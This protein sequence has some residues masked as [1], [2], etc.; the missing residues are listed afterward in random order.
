MILAEHKSFSTASSL[1]ILS[2]EELIKAILVLLHSEE[3]KVYRLKEANKFFKDHSIRHHLA[4][5]IETGKGLLEAREKWGTSNLN[6]ISTKTTIGEILNHVYSGFQA[7]KPLSKSIN[8]VEKLQGFNTLKNY[9]FY[10]DYSDGLK[11]PKVEIT[12]S[13][14]EDVVSINQRIMTFYKKLSLLF[15]PLIYKYRSEKEVINLRQDLHL[16]ID[17]ALNGFSLNELKNL[18]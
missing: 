13:D 9:G 14:F 18:K 3:Y 15:H 1:M 5:L 16:F 11:V 4:Q 12:K 2:T 10:V 7:Y 6:S 17:S 8:R